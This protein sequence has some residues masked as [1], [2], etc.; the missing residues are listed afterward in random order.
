MYCINCGVKLP[1]AKCRC[2]RFFA[3]AASVVLFLCLLGSPFLAFAS[4]ASGTDT[5]ERLHDAII[6]DYDDIAY[7]NY[8]DPDREDRSDEEWDDDGRDA[9]DYGEYVEHS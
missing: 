2:G 5:S 4:K 6:N 7:D 8:Y 3:I 9:D 1:D